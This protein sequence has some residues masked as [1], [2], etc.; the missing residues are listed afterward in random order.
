[1]TNLVRRPHGGGSRPFEPIVVE[2]IR[3]LRR[4]GDSI[5]EIRKK[6]SFSH[7]VIVKYCKGIR[8]GT[9]PSTM[10]S[11]SSL[12]VEGHLRS[13]SPGQSQPS[14]RVSPN[15]LPASS[16][17]RAQD[18]GIQ[19]SSVP[20]RTIET[21]RDFR[22]IPPKRFNLEEAIKDVHRAYL[23]GIEVRLFLRA[24]ESHDIILDIDGF[25]RREAERMRPQIVSELK[26]IDREVRAMHWQ[27]DRASS[28]LS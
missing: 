13:R 1:M 4:K 10:T 18:P 17:P 15:R 20:A 23:D 6:T 5:E 11:S 7:G 24:A 25:V 21:P 19:W 28:F 3:N 12:P 2:I 27:I 22:P 26:R 16:P 8:R 14:P 9:P